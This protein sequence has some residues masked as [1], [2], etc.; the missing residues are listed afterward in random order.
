MSDDGGSRLQADP[1]F[2]GLAR[3]PMAMGVSYMYFVVNALFSMMSFIWSQNFIILFFM[4]PM[5][6]L[7]GYLICLN[8]PRAVELMILRMGKGMRCV[9]RRFHKYTNSYDVF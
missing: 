9:N 8:E 2:Q 6:H 3:P 5:I 1:L 7:V 4:A